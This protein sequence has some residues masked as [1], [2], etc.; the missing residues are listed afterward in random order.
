[1]IG[2]IS[3]RYFGKRLL[4]CFHIAHTDPLGYVDVPFGPLLTLFNGRGYC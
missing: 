3:G 1:M 2:S 4:D